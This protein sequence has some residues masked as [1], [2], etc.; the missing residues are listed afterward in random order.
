MQAMKRISTGSETEL[1]LKVLVGGE[2]TNK[3]VVGELG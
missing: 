1:V 3:G 2:E